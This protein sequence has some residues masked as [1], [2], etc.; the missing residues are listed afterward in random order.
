MADPTGETDGSAL[1]LDFDCR[2]MLQFRGST[3]TSDAGFGGR[4]A[5]TDVRR[6]PV[7][8]RPAAG[9]ARA[10]MSGTEA[11]S[12]IR[13]REQRESCALMK[14]E[15]PTLTL[16]GREH[17]ASAADDVRLPTKRVATEP[18]Q[19]DHVPSGLAHE[20]CRF[21]TRSFQRSATDGIPQ[22]YRISPFWT[23]SD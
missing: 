11:E 7:A 13:Q 23:M 2:L 12:D 1:R 10:S 22:S 8:D 21:S 17:I 9:T 16:A 20:V 14:A 18:Q 3:I 6:D 5:A 19:A 4:G 15:P